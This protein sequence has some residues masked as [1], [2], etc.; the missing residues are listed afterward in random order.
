MDKPL[1]WQDEDAYWQ[2]NYR[3]RPYAS[4]S[5]DYGVWR[6]GY[7]YGYEAAKR[8]E[9]RPWD[10]VEADRSHGWS[11]YEHRGTSTWDQMKAAVRD[12]WDRVT[13]HRT[14]VTK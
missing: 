14:T 11:T 13:H 1:S 10:D 3:S 7:R 12:A 8:Y 9:G 4:T 5:P 6:G 2:S